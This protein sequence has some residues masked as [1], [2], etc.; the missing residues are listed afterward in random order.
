[1]SMRKYLRDFAKMNASVQAH[2]HSERQK[3][4]REYL[5]QLTRKNA[6][7]QA[8]MEQQQHYRETAERIT[9]GYSKA[10]SASSHR[11][12]SVIEGCVAGI[13][14]VEREIKQR[15]EEYTELTREIEAAI[16]RIPDD[17]YRDILRWRY[18]NGWKWERIA[19][20]MNYSDMKW[21]WNLHRRALEALEVPPLKH[22]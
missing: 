13:D 22:D 6:R 10:P 14:E 12:G 9:R 21:L 18:V 4:A 1:M 8:L 7:I 20:E 15:I 11:A 16:A 17:R 19:K 2:A 5:S 3:A